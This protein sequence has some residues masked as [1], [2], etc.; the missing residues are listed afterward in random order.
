MRSWILIAALA[1]GTTGFVSAAYCAESAKEE[2]AETKVTMDSLPKAVQ[3]TIKREAGSGTLGE[4]SK[5]AKDGKTAYE[6]DATIDGKKY[7]IKV[8]EDG[9]LISKKLE[10][11]EAKDEKEDKD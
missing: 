3:D 8:M 2:A 10:K 1:A 5:E 6:A 7:E 9:T 4:V 11:S